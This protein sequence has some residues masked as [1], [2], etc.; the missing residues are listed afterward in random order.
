MSQFEGPKNL[1]L[2]QICQRSFQRRLSQ[3][4]GLNWISEP[5]WLP[6]H[7]LVRVE[8]GRTTGISRLSNQ[9]VCAIWAPS[10]PRR[11]NFTAAVIAFFRLDRTISRRIHSLPVFCSASSVHQRRCIPLR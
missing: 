5:Y 3:I 11:K 6:S 10:I 2:V 1:N 7:Y 4:K 8:V 9:G